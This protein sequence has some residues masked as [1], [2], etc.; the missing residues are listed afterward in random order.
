MKL[1][2]C[3]WY[4]YRKAGARGKEVTIL[5]RTPTA[6]DLL[7]EFDIFIRNARTPSEK[8]MLIH[9]KGRLSMLDNASFQKNYIDVRSLKHGINSF[10]LGT[11]KSEEMRL[12]YIHELLRRLYQGMKQN[13]KERGVSMY[14]VIDEAEF[15]INSEGS[16]SETISQLIG[17]GRKYGVGVILATHTAGSLS[18]QI[19]ANASTFIAF[20]SRE[21]TDVNYIANILSGG[22]QEKAF[23]IK[24]RLHSLK[25]NEA[26]LISGRF[27]EPAVFSTKKADLITQQPQPPTKNKDFA[28]RLLE[29]ARNP[30]RLQ[31]LQREVGAVSADELSSIGIESATSKMD[32]TDEQWCMSRKSAMSLEHEINV[33][34]ISEI[35]SA[36]EISNSIIDNANGPDI[37]A[38]INGVKVAIEYETGRKR[39]EETVS[40]LKGRLAYYHKV[41][42]FVNDAHFDSY[43]KALAGIG[44]KV[45]GA[46]SIKSTIE[47]L[48]AQQSPD[49]HGPL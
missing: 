31:Q 47:L 34:K 38:Y 22:M 36:N 1:S 41:M 16:G 17:E 4:T 14:I 5:T 39:I 30:I 25:V 11:M 20:Y 37:S 42:V 10:S 29:L 8:N 13:E 24:S 49:Y 46:S 18:K 3:L 19:I 15:L 44:I 33:T 23:A 21:P 43:S 40:M 27:R 32:G 28:A 12:I 9:L 7:K 6:R 48:A 35:L 26:M 45:Y 2:Q